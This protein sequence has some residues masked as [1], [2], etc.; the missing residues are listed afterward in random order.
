MNKRPMKKKLLL[1][2]ML[3]IVMLGNSQNETLYSPDKKL[4][5][6]IDC[7]SGQLQYSIYTTDNEQKPFDDFGLLPQYRAIAQFHANA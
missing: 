6:K 3:G 2:L 1:I 7:T 4:A 5:V